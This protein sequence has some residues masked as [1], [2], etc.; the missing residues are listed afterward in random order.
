MKKNFE[1]EL[2]I[3]LQAASDAGKLTLQYF[4]TRSL[5]VETKKDQ[6]PVTLADKNAEKKI[7]EMLTKYF[8]NDGILGE[9]FG[10]V[11]GKSNRKWIIDPIDGTKSFTHGVPFY[12]VMIGLEVAGVCSLGVV[13]FP[14]LGEL[15]YAVKGTG[16]FCNG[17]RLHVSDTK[18]SD[19]VYLMTDIQHIQK[20]GQTSLY[21]AL[22]AQAKFSRTWG[23]CYG[24]YLVA[25]GRAEV[26]HD[27]VMNPWDCAAVIP[28]IEEA[29]GKWCDLLGKPTIYGKGLIATNK[30][31]FA[32]VKKLL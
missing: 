29:G 19:G 18:L 31:C 32:D 21:E 28:I 10:E 8:P 23:D 16:A 25:S 15:T 20:Q 24:H 7:R 12:G 13:N 4:Q 26:M 2:D 14:A 3:A 27:P 6:S 9:E 30:T 17:Q 1:T 22:S 5:K 11:K